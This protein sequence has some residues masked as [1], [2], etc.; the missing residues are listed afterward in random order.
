MKLYKQDVPL[1]ISN[2][3]FA[4]AA[5][6]VIAAAMVW[7]GYFTGTSNSDSGHRKGAGN[8]RRLAGQ[9]AAGGVE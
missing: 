6:C 1:L 4:V 3:V 5:G 2:T 7:M 9:H 8:R